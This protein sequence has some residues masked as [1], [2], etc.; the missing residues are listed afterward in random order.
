MSDPGLYSL[1]W[2]EGKLSV[3]SFVASVAGGYFNVVVLPA[4]EDPSRRK[5]GF[6]TGTDRFYEASWRAYR[7][8]RTGLFQYHV[9]RAES[10]PP[11][12]AVVAD[13]DPGLGER[14]AGAAAGAGGPTGRGAARGPRE[15]LAS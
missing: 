12:S 10:R 15:A 4:D 2:T 13:P 11:A 9:W 7:L 14:S 6:R 8:D 1:L 5:Y 3:D